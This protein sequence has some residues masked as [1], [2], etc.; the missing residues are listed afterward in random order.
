MHIE[1]PLASQLVSLAFTI[2]ACG[3]IGF[4]REYHGK[5]AGMR[6]NVL[7]GMGSWLFTMVSLYG[8]NIVEGTG[9]SWDASRIAAQIVSGIG[10]IG[11]G[12]IFY[13]HA[14]VKGLTTA[15][16]VWV[17]AAI[18]MASACNLL[19]LTAIVTACYFI[20]ILFVAPATYKLSHLYQSSTLEISYENGRGSLRQILLTLNREGFETQLL[21]SRQVDRHGWSGVVVGIRVRGHISA[22]TFDFIMN[23]EGVKG[24]DLV[25]DRDQDW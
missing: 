14:N 5:D 13:N 25:D 7:V 2:V 8:Y 24:V 15:A 12:V 20:I 10:F 16:G 1:I 4:E 6:T 11:A 9:V 18:G 21:S 22:D 17:A 3:L 19:I 23:T